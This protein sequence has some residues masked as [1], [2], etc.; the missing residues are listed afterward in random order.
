MPGILLL[1]ERLYEGK[2]ENKLLLY[3]HTET[4]FGKL[5]SQMPRQ[6]NPPGYRYFCAILLP[7]IRFSQA[8]RWT[9][10]MSDFTIDII[11]KA[12]FRSVVSF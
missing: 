1:K 11:Y 4:D 2:K 12:I 3:S 9:V 6:T 8:S 7:T 10:M 5:L